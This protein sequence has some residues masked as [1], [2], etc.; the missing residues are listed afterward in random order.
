MS[1]AWADSLCP[2]SGLASFGL[3]KGVDSW[4]LDENVKRQPPETVGGSSL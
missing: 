3:P 1:R 2:L 4:D